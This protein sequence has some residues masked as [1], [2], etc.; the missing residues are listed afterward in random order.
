MA[1][2]DDLWCPPFGEPIAEVRERAARFLAGL[3]SFS[4][5]AVVTHGETIRCLL[6]E[7]SPV[8]PHE[9]PAFR[10]PNG[11]VVWFPLSSRPRTNAGPPH[12]CD[13]PMDSTGRAR[14][15]RD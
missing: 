1:A 13:G 2:A 10:V 8:R 7:V 14:S 5:V 15:Y 6:A 11:S 9:T 3:D 4:T 12:E